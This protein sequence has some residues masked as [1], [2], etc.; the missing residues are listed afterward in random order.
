MYKLRYLLPNNQTIL[1]QQLRQNPRWTP[2]N[3]FSLESALAPVRARAQVGRSTIQPFERILGCFFP[4]KSGLVTMVWPRMIIR[5][6]EGLALQ[7]LHRF[8][9]MWLWENHLI[10]EPQFFRLLNGDNTCPFL[11]YEVVTKW[12][13][14]GK[15]DL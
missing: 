3:T 14:G 11:L 7:L 2:A 5:L 1:L 6:R 9:V 4:P 10:S 15:D 13:I 8:L 12:G